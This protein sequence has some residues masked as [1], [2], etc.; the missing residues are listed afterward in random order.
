MFGPKPSLLGSSQEIS[1]KVSCDANASEAAPSQGGAA[2]FAGMWEW[3]CGKRGT[4]VALRRS[5][6]TGE[7]GDKDRR[8]DRGRVSP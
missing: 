6:A 5:I 8:H 3:G 2:F 1:G 7:T 4:D